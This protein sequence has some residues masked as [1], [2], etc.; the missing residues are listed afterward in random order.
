[1]SYQE[2]VR[3][4]ERFRESQRYWRRRSRITLAV[5]FLFWGVAL[6]L[7]WWSGHR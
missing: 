6:A 4:T 3:R 2:D 7:A 1:M 5:F